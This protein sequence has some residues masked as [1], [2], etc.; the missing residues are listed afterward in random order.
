MITPL[1]AA[2]AIKYLHAA[3]AMNAVDD[4][5]IVWADYLNSP[6]AKCELATD[7]DLLPAARQC[8]KTWNQSDDG[9]R[10]KVNVDDFARH[11][12]T[13][14]SQKITEI[15]GLTSNNVSSWELSPRFIGGFDRYAYEQV[16]IG[17]CRKLAETMTDRESIWK[18]AAKN[19]MSEHG[20]SFDPDR[21]QPEWVR[22]AYQIEAANV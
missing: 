18:Q 17:E 21:E 9:Y 16:W 14:H 15:C 12:R 22:N 19:V 4:Q 11:V 13:T 6:E 7:A 5:E 3:G 2:Q 8:I 10:R 1:G 20:L